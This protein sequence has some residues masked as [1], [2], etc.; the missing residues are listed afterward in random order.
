M[1]DPAPLT[2][3]D[4]QMIDQLTIRLDR[5]GAQLAMLSKPE[6]EAGTSPEHA[7][8]NSAASSHGNGIAS[9]RVPKGAADSHGPSA[10]T[11]HG[12]R[13]PVLPNQSSRSLTRARLNVL[14]GDRRGTVAAL[15][16]TSIVTGFTEAAILAIL[17]QVAASL[18]S[19]T[20][21]VHIDHGPVDFHTGLGT[22]LLVAF[23]LALFRLALQAPLS[24]LPARI[25]ASVQS[26]LRQNLFGAFTRASWDVQS[27]DREGHLQETMTS[28][29]IQATGGALQATTL[30]TALFTFIVLMLSA[31]ALNARAAGVVLGA[32]AL[33]FG[34][35][36]PLNTLGARRA[37]SLS[38][39]QM[40]YAGGVGEAIRLTEE[41]HVFGV[42]AAQRERIG[43]LVG[44]AQDLFFRTQ[45]IARLIPNLYQSLMYLLLI[46]LLAGLHAAGGGHAA[47]LGA[48]VLL[49]LRAGTN[50]QQMQGAYQAL[51]QSLPFV[52][53]LQA[54]ELR[55]TQSRL[56]SGER[57]LA[58]I[59]TLAFERVC[60]G[61]RADRP[62]LSDIDFQVNAGEVVG[63]IGPS[64]AG[65]STLVQILLQLRS[66][67]SGRY[68]V[69]GVPAREFAPEDWHSRVAYVPQ[70]PRL[71]HASVA[72]NIRYFRAL[73]DH[74]LERA[75]QLARI[76]GDIMTWPNG[77]QTI[78]GPRADAVSGGQQQRI[79][80]ARA[81][82]ARPQVLV[83][84]EPTSALD[85]HSE[86]L[87]QESLTALKSGLTMFIVAHRMSTLDICDR[88]MVIL[89]GRL[90]A[91]DTLDLMRTQNSYYRSAAM[92]AA[93]T[94]G[95]MPS[96]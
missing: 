52:E 41:T 61:Y 5:A 38:N 51:R 72:D 95:S 37:R 11:A 83:L 57:P 77:Y 66:P 23:C 16:A 73:D 90:A 26:Q 6:S 47:S 93:G 19:G 64:G 45:L 55:Y 84:D 22:L 39:A 96:R 42:A 33:L 13:D 75:A 87:I 94:S 91:F 27:G 46:G 30:M 21:R 17:A 69:N 3:A 89:D 36:R 81:L 62:V 80:L 4:R 31:L 9:S 74:A 82:A 20:E 18:V 43:E 53:R 10:A 88:V 86:T 67:G 7:S 8:P 56:A 70:E 35:L 85:P 48:V 65:K 28:Q 59:Q 79:C 92:L 50:G 12:P 58:K 68:L 54:T 40:E 32:A 29:V 24:I 71:V 78:V 25:A 49:L 76:D 60:F 34:L 15:A 2:P 1:T 44:T 14:F 63:I